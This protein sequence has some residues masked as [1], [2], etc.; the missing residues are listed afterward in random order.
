MEIAQLL[1]AFKRGEKFASVFARVAQAHEGVHGGHDIYHTVR[2]ANC[3]GLIATTEWN[4]QRITDLSILAGLCHNADRL[5]EKK[6][7]NPKLIEM[8]VRSWLNG[9]PMSIGEKE[10]VIDAVL[11]HSGPNK[12][13]HSQ[14]AKATGDGDREVNME[15]D[16]V[17]RSAQ[18]YHDLPA[19][20]YVHFL[21]DPEATYKHPRSVLKDISACLE[22]VD[23]QSPFCFQ[24]ETG[25]A[26]G[27][28][29]A[30]ALKDFIDTLEQ[31]LKAGGL[32]Q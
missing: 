3:A 19:V 8:L 4:D 24:T 17:I 32:L 1:S 29:R 30:R 16:V 9:T 13:R 21:G 18:Y 22:W 11:V 10:M 27:K 25:M 20:D 26:L 6:T 5:L 14:V 12:L 7:D 2:V 31:Q 15:L 28:E 23:P